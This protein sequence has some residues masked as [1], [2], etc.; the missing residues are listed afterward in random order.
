MAYL[1][2]RRKALFYKG[3]NG[4]W[5]RGINSA[6]CCLNGRMQYAPTF[7][8]EMGTG[9][10]FCLVL[11]AGAQKK[12]IPISLVNF[13]FSIYFSIVFLHAIRSNNK[14]GFLGTDVV[15]LKNTQHWRNRT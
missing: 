12:S 9:F 11:N 14:V 10:T 15:I 7:L 3:F 13:L 4:V 5:S 1:G 8:K 2:C 6:P